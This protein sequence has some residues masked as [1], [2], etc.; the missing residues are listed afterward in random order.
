MI[1]SA[2][3]EPS[4]YAFVPEGSVSTGKSMPNFFAKAGKVWWMEGLMNMIIRSCNVSRLSGCLTEW[5]ISL[6]LTLVLETSVRFI[7]SLTWFFSRSEPPWP[8]K[9]PVMKVNR[10][11]NTV[12]GQLIRS[13]YLFD[14]KKVQVFRIP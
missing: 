14:W 8:R 4:Q 13:S 12:H 3:G 7:A 11:M 2:W 6:D 5:M 10:P 9:G 1:F